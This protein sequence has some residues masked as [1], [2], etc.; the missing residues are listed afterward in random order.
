MPL[1][2]IVIYSWYPFSKF[3]E[4]QSRLAEIVEE[5]GTSTAIKSITNFTSAGKKGVRVAAYHEIE[6][7]KVEEALNYL[8]EFMS[9]F[10]TI[11]GYTY[12]FDFALSPEDAQNFAPRV[13]KY[14][15][16]Q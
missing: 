13:S 14:A 10:W 9:G 4:V 12:R 11:E 3:Q 15:F 7:G 1:A 16:K 5:K 2:H 6:D 8:G